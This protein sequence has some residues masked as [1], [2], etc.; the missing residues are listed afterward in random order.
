MREAFT[1]W[2]ISRG[3]L[4]LLLVTLPLSFGVS[5]ILAHSLTPANLSLIPFGDLWLSYDPHRGLWL[6]GTA[7]AGIGLA[8]IGSRRQAASSHTS[9]SVLWGRSPVGP[10][11][12]VAVGLGLGI[13]A[14]GPLILNAA[15]Y[16]Q[17]EAGQAFVSLA[18]LLLVLALVSAGV[19]SK[20]RRGLAGLATGT[21]MVVLFGYGTR[22]FAAAPLLYMVGRYLSG[23]PVSKKLIAI[24]AST[25]LL[26]L[27]IPLYMRGLTEH[28]LLP[29]S[30]ELVRN[31]PKVYELGSLKVM[32]NLGFTFPVADMTYRSPTL[33]PPHSLWTSVN[34][35]PS[36]MA[37][38]DRVGPLMRVNYYVPFSFFGEW[39]SMGLL[40]LFFASFVWGLIVRW[41]IASTLQLVGTTRWA[42]FAVII[43]L[44]LG[45]LSALY[46]LQYNTRS[47]AR[48]LDIMII[49]AI[50][51][52]GHVALGAR[53]VARNG[54]N[55]GVS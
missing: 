12:I 43:A 30:T 38:W 4:F 19:L 55:L 17:F 10:V 29:Y 24:C 39:A 22:V 14:K 37:G 18:Q 45:C 52:R 49:I 31:L 28:G 7:M 9:L 47:V 50:A 32:S 16:G 11:I 23:A 1:P 2:W 15:T 21:L 53:N 54:P 6:M 36:S 34:P 40:T 44:G 46:C 5:L 42:M 8:S 3:P 41:S 27:P 48:I 33:V 20:D 26:L 25:A 13:W 51:V 35:L